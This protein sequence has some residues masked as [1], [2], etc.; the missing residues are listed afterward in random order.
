MLLKLCPAV[1]PILS[2]NG[3]LGVF[4]GEIGLKDLVVGEVRP[5]RKSMT[6]AVGDLHGH[7]PMAVYEVLG[8]ITELL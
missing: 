7:G 8:L 2:G 4:Q 5:L 6:D 3:T 1:E